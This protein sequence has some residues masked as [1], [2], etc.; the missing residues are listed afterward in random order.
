M[1]NL[2]FTIGTFDIVHEGHLQLI[3]RCRQ[4]AGGKGLVH[5]GVNYDDIVEKRGK[6]LMQVAVFRQRVVEQ[7]KDVDS[8]FLYFGEPYKIVERF[9]RYEA[10]VHQVG[11][12]PARILVVGDDWAPMSRYAELL[13]VKPTWFDENQITLVFVPYTQGFSST[14]LRER[15]N[16]RKQREA[17]G[18]DAIEG[19]S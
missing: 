4:L 16:E 6:K 8:T 15:L 10:V 1:S 5:V 3:R 2:V 9:D 18:T 13:G 19:R 7:L 12:Y 14:L 17:G 11:V